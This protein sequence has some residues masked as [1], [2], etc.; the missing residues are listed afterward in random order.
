MTKRNSKRSRRT[1][2]A[3]EPAATI[4]RPTD[5][6]RRPVAVMVDHA[7]GRLVIFTDDILINQLRR[8]GPKIELSFDKLCSRDIAEIS[9]LMSNIVSILFS[10]MRS[11]AS[12]QLMLE[13]ACAKL[14]VN[15]S[16][17]LGAATALLRLGYCLQPGIIIRSM[18]EAIST[19]LHLIQNPKDFQKYETGKLS[20]PSTIAAAKKAIPVFGNL[21]GYFSD[22][23]AHM[24]HLHQSVSKFGEF[25]E[26]H[27]GLETNL[28]FL[29][30]ASWLLYVT[31]ELLFNDLVKEPRYWKIDPVGYRYEP[32]EAERKW[33]HEYLGGNEAA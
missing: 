26:R 17:S 29:R 19:V 32:S 33:M 18:L 12:Q 8:D 2:S 31:T 22:N 6:Q 3:V 30:L 7:E 1:K 11:A 24:G 9:T 27:A 15:A 5:A 25:S 16:H 10:G 21:Y 23:F 4:A 13:V 28:G 20:S 14:L